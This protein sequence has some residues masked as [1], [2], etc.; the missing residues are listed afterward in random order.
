MDIDQLATA[1]GKQFVTAW[2]A[3]VPFLAAMIAGWLVIRWFIRDQYETRLANAA[4]KL[5][6]ADARVQDYERKLAGASPDEAKADLDRA[7]G[8]IEALEKAAAIMAPRRITDA[9]KAIMGRVL[10]AIV[11]HI[12]VGYVMGANDGLNFR[13]DF[14][15]V[16]NEAG[17]TVSR[18][19]Y[20]SP[21][22]IGAGITMNINRDTPAAK[23]AISAVQAAGFAIGVRTQ[24][25]PEPDSWD[26]SLIIN[27]IG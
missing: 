18:T 10:S 7:H 1:I 6:L 23:I 25:R 22:S 5:D 21:E 26:A 17:W 11:G 2:N 8:R 3:P 27:T 20:H 4:S 12:N 24:L 13:Q 15:D 19:V 16:F 14:A 9:Q